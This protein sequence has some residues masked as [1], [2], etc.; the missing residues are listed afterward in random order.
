MSGSRSIE[1]LSKLQQA[2]NPEA[3]AGMAHFGINPRNTLGVSIPVL[4]QIAKE[5][6]KDHSLAE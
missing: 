2:A 4:R 1:I 3:V 5:S 6:G